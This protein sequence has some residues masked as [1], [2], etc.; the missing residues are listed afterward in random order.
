MAQALVAQALSLVPVS[1]LMVHVLGLRK[2]LVALALPDLIRVDVALHPIN[3]VRGD[4][5]H[6]M[7]GSSPMVNQRESD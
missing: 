2:I 7:G 3:A 1:V 5:N 6:G 4:F